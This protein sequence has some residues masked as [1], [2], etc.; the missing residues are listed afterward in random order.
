MPTSP[1]ALAVLGLHASATPTL[2]DVRARFLERALE[3]HPDKK[4]GSTE[5]FQELQEAYEMARQCDLANWVTPQE[6]ARM[7]ATS[8]A[9]AAGVAKARANSDAELARLR[10]KWA[11]EGTLRQKATTTKPAKP[12]KPAKPTSA[13]SVFDATPANPHLIQQLVIQLEEGEPYVR[14]REREGGGG[15]EGGGHSISPMSYCDEWGK[16]RLA[17]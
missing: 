12:A 1:D 8:E 3:C 5:A 14:K 7:W 11:R 2:A 16:M 13:A 17:V 15:G 6:K 4:G 9:I 10:R